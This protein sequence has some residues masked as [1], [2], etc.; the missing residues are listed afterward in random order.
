MPDT[1]RAELRKLLTAAAVEAA[2][3]RFREPVR[4]LARTFQSAS[5]VV[6]DAL[7]A[8]A[9]DPVRLDAVSGLIIGA[10]ADEVLGDVPGLI[11]AVESNSLWAT[12]QQLLDVALP[13]RAGPTAG[14]L[15]KATGVE[16]SAAAG[17]LAVTAILAMGVVARRIGDGPLGV[18]RLAD[19]LASANERPSLVGALQ[20]PARPSKDGRTASPATIR[21]RS[22]LL[23]TRHEPPPGRGA[24][25]WL[26]LVVLA[27][28]GLFAW[29]DRLPRPQALVS[30]PKTVQPDAIAMRLPAT[31]PPR[32]ARSEQ[33][34]TLSSKAGNLPPA[35]PPLAS[36]TPALPALPA[37]RPE[38]PAAQPAIRPAPVVTPS[39]AATPA[40]APRIEVAA[41]PRDTA[42][43]PPPAAAQP[44]PPPLPPP[45]V[46]ITAMRDDVPAIPPIAATP[47]PVATPT[48]PQLAESIESRLIGLIEDRSR[49]LDALTWFDLEGI[50]FRTGSASLSPGSREQIEIL[51]E[52]LSLFPTVRLTL[53]GHS[54]NQGEPAANI[55]L[56]AGR[57][58]SVAAALRELGIAADRL[59]VVGLGAQRP[60]AD[61]ATTA[62]RARNRRIAVQVTAR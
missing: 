12:A 27:G 38:P 29:E 17:V 58:Q 1:I 36:P 55:N 31:Q 21:S 9:K 4:V 25:A 32:P 35:Q 26:A 53:A 16:T 51:A 49:P 5:S 23:P 6:L 45:R 60:I 40:P 59:A 11:A 13:Q 52:I 20:R 30:G 7:T 47:S 8:C 37:P 22:A 62:G 24:A 50:T 34:R 15:A 46:D 19:I 3:V 48:G 33:P 44:G 57:A 54:D 14:H 42:T 43:E 28:A 2:S 39:P 41:P 61:N 10:Q 18:S 56:S